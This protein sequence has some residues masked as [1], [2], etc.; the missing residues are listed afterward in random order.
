MELKAFKTQLK[1]L[2][3]HVNT[4]KSH[5]TSEADVRRSL[6]LP[7]F[8]AL[9]YNIHSASEVKAEYPIPTGKNKPDQ[10]DLVIMRDGK[11]CIIVECK[12]GNINDPASKAQL[13]TYFHN[14]TDS[15]FGVLTSG[16]QYQFFCDKDQANIM[17]DEPFFTFDVTE[18]KDDEVDI[19]RQFHRS[20]FDLN[21]IVDITQE[22]MRMTGIKRNI[23]AEMNDPT[24]DFVR[25]ITRNFVKFARGTAAQKQMEELKASTKKAFSMIIA[26]RLPKKQVQV[27]AP[28]PAD[29]IVVEDTQSETECFHAIQTA[30][31]LKEAC[32]PDRLFLRE[33]ANHVL[34][35]LDNNQQKPMVRLYFG[36]EQ[37]FIEVCSDA[38]NSRRHEYNSIKDV[39]PC[40]QTMTE[41]V[42]IYDGKRQ[43]RAEQTQEAVQETTVEE[44]QNDGGNARITTVGIEIDGERREVTKKELFALAKEGIVQPDTRVF[45]GD[46]AATASR[47][48]GIEFGGD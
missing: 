43:S 14:L 20:I 15:K 35:C 19:L 42:E 16:V 11:P 21:T 12:R 44:E 47:I 29:T 46:Q 39:F 45:F 26:E 23:I 31:A 33:R 1:S 48:R 38:K 3:E 7:L 9:G 30:L 40:I 36:D 6:V 22:Q 25:H 41:T 27:A 34:V 13:K 24:D 4:E 8:H 10:A 17:E 32:E 5:I 18:M 37:K 2:A 28:V